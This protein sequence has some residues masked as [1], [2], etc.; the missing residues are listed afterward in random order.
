MEDLGIDR[1]FLRPETTRLL[2]SVNGSYTYF[3]NGDVLL[4][5]ITPCF[6]NGKL[7]IADRLK[8]AIGFGSSEFIVLRPNSSLNK[9]FLYYYLLR[10]DFRTEGAA[11][12]GGAVGQQRVPRDFIEKYSIPLPPIQEQKRIV[13]ILDEVFAAI[14]KAKANA[15]KN[16][17]NVRALF[18]SHLDAVFTHHG[19][20][21]QLNTVGELVNEGVLFK[22]F[23]GNHGEIHPKRADY[24]DAGVPFIMASDLDNGHVDTQHCKFLAKKQADSLRVGFAEDGDVLLSHK[25]TIGRSAILDTEDDYVMLTPQVTA[26]RINDKTRLYNRFIRYYFMSPIFQ[27]EII[28]GAEGGSTRA[29]I[30]IT[31]QLVLHFRFPSLD[32]QK[33][34]ATQFDSLAKETQRLK[35]IYQQKLAA[36]EALK[37]S[38]LHQAFTGAL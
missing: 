28:A 21:W 15:E 19:Q 32:A 3:A 37:K 9:E 2:S 30:G 4:A 36:L 31:K 38:L 18:E 24:V 35:F 33:K 23:D 27:K 22:P 29:Y 26:Y 10:P 8:N 17:Q 12:M 5:K 20:G 7:G 13:G 34:I 14:A 11:R 16:L 1:K 25:A 6:E